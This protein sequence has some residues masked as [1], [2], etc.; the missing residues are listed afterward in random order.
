MLQSGTCLL[1]ADDTAIFFESDS[2]EHMQSKINEEIPKI[3]NWLNVNKLSLN[4]EKTMGQLYSNT[5]KVKNIEVKINGK[6]IK[7]V[8]T[9]KYLGVFIDRKLTWRDH[10]TSLANVISRNIGILY[11]SS[12]ILERDPLLLLY[13]VLILSHINYCCLVWGMTFPTLVNKIEILQKKA[14]RIITGIGCIAH[15]EPL[16]KELKVLKAKDIA[17]QQ[18]LILI[19]KKIKGALPSSLEHLFHKNEQHTY[20]NN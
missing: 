16:F 3:C 20:V 13:N 7:F 19:H 14:V 15:S 18:A 2:E 6:S 5:T 8:E 9:V 1:Y 4:T 10:I 11:R 17:K 12:F